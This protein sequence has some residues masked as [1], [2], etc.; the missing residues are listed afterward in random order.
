M[1]KYNLQKPHERVRHLLLKMS[2]STTRNTMYAFTLYYRFYFAV[3]PN[4]GINKGM[5]KLLK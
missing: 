4:R 3:N 2:C 1:V 5:C